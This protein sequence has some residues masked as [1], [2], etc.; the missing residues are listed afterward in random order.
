MGLPELE[1]DVN[2]FMRSHRS[3]SRRRIA[4]ATQ[5]RFVDAQKEIDIL[6]GKT[7]EEATT[8]ILEPLRALVFPSQAS[9]PVISGERSN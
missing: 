8:D 2:D 9:L 5:A 4:Q 1:E 6:E 3:I 7:E